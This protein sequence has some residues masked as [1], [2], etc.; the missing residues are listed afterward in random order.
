MGEARN[1][2]SCRQNVKESKKFEDLEEDGRNVKLVLKRW[3]L[4]S[5]APK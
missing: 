4:K 5:W 2:G 3:L 1:I